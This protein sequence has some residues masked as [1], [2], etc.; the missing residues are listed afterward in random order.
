MGEDLVRARLDKLEDLRR[1]GLDP[2]PARVPSTEA[3]ASVLERHA[4]LS[5]DE[6]SGDRVTVAGRLT[7]IR[8]MGK[9]SFLDVRDGT[10]KI[11]AHASVDRMGEAPYDDLRHLD[12]GDFLAVSGEV[13][14][15]KRG[16]LTVATESWTFLAKAVRPLP[17]KWHGLKDIELRYRQRS[18][19]LLANDESRERFVR[20]A[21]M[22]ATLRSELTALGFL[23]VETPSLH[24]IPG[25][26]SARPFIT[27][28]NALDTDFYLRIA[29]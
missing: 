10:G 18:L 19:D 22:M 8:Q 5:P 26:T 7:A 9:A 2:F 29:L 11:Q 27:H 1:R 20:R 16:E 15:T 12:V 25:G 23:E 17:E 13:F 28:H 4:A 21:N 3:V 6:H 14:R 24:P